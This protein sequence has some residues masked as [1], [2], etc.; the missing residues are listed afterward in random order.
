MPDRTREPNPAERQS[1]STPR[2]PGAI[3]T[4]NVRDEVARPDAELLPFDPQEGS[5]QR[6]S[7]LERTQLQSD[8]ELE[9]ARR[10]ADEDYRRAQSELNARRRDVH[11]QQLDRERQEALKSIEEQEKALRERQQA[12]GAMFIDQG[13]IEAQGALSRARAAALKQDETVPGG[14]YIVAGRHVD[15]DG[16]WLD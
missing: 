15:A 9:D 10:K 14:H 2:D 16:N 7:D 4:S 8:A 13:L 11:G 6:L 1:P 12:S 3:S 5:G